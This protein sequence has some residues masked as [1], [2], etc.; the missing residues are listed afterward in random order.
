MPLSGHEQLQA[1]M[2]TR[3]GNGI[4]RVEQL[5]EQA[6]TRA[7]RSF[8]LTLPQYVTLMVLHY[9]PGQ[10]AA[11]LSRT[12]LVSTQ[13]IATILGNLERKNLVTRDVSDLHARV[14]V[15]ELTPEGHA[16]AVESDE[17]VRAVESDLRAEYTD[18]EFAQFQEFLER[19]EAHLLAGRIAA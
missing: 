1:E 6:K 16:L 13:T 18:T 11:Q 4:K 8:S 19:A 17:K 3:V 9:V 5:L 2:S 14:L 15:N 7:L 10:S 12:A